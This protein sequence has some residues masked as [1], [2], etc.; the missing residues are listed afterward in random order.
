MGEVVILDFVFF[1]LTWCPGQFASTSTNLT[2]PKVN[3]YVNL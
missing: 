2:S 1:R 3:D